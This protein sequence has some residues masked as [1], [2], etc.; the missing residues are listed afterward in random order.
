[1]K[2]L[3]FLPVMAAMVLC[4]TPRVEAEPAWGVN[5]LSCHSEWQADL[6]TVMGESYVA[7][8]DETATGAPDRGPLP[9]FEVLVGA[10]GNLQVEIAGL[11]PGDTYAVELKRLR[12]P[13]VEAGGE[14]VYTADCVWGYWGEPGKY[15]TDPGLAYVWG[16]GP[17]T[18]TYNIQPLAG[19]PVD[20]YDLVF[21]V[22]G[23]LAG[24]TTLFSSEEHFYLRVA[25]L[26]G[27]MDYDNDIDG[28]DFVIFEGCFS[29][30]NVPLGAGCEAG[31]FDSDGDIDCLDWDGFVS[32]WTNGDQAIP[33]LAACRGVIP[34]VSD[35]G[36]AIMVLLVM[37]AA[38]LAYRPVVP[39]LCRATR[40]SR[41]RHGFFGLTLALVCGHGLPAQASDLNVSLEAIGC[42]ASTITVGP[43]CDVSYRV[44]GELS[45]AAGDGLALFLVDVEFDGGPLAKADDPT[46]APMTNFLPPGGFSSN[47]EGFGGTPS[48]NSLLQVGGAQNLFHHGQWA[49]VDDGDCP[50]KS[51]CD[52]QFCSPLTGLGTGTVTKD[53][54]DQG[55]PLVLVIG[56]VTAPTAPGTYTLQVTRVVATAIKAGATGTPVWFTEPVGTGTLS[57]LTITVD[58]GGSCCADIARGRPMADDAF[59]VDGTVRTCTTDLDCLLGISANSLTYCV[60]PPAGGAGDGVCYVQR[61]RYISIN[62]NAANSGKTSARRVLLDLGGGS[63]SLV[64]WVGAP[65]E[66]NVTGPVDGTPE[67]TPQ[68]LSRIVDAPYY[69]DWAVND[70]GQPWV[71]ASVHAG[72]CAISPG[73]TFIVQAIAEG[74]NLV[75]ENAYSEPLTLK[76]TLEYGDVVGGT[77]GT[78]PDTVRNFKDISGAVAG[79]QSMQTVPRVWIDLAGPTSDLE[80]PDFSDIN[81]TDINMAVSGFQGGSY[82][83]CP[84][85]DC[86]N[87]GAACHP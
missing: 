2:R 71:D 50:G 3:V 79:F 46:L 60:L 68:L 30:P 7:D 55:S 10:S 16:S 87:A 65:V 15:Y 48:G 35:W 17:T 63:T 21:A 57:S 81:F 67:P 22:A 78:P 8:P 66:T 41:V 53:V 37:V 86:A 23:K 5:C 45:D 4:P 43:G 6:V 69:R 64:G 9:V 1:M 49:C 62:P 38:T 26:M 58:A 32:A 40:S 25:P 12:F 52:G 39:A 80:A 36:L 31:D 11:A 61:N 33:N 85:L 28:A 24:S 56:T 34:A 14:L 72:D 73:Y 19:A 77:P 51:I 76:T 82:P 83:Y 54:A 74:A 18:F 44:W 47:P 70:S 84:P 42:E 20:Y 27:D 59:D 75:D 13:G 29:G